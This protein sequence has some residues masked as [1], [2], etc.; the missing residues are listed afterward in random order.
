VRIEEEPVS[1]PRGLVAALLAAAAL[2]PTAAP[3]LQRVEVRISDHRYAPET[4]TVRRGATV[5][6]VNED[7]D[8]HTV[9]SDRDAFASPGMDKREDFTFSFDAPGRYPYH[10]A[11]HPM[12]TGTVVVK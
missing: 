10:C 9:T 7:D 12:M 3:P 1:A 5:R 6:W 11:L 4:I 2:S 8:P